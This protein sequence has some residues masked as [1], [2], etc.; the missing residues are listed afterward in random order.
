M[1]SK[2][3]TE[4]PFCVIITGDFN[5]RSAQWWENDMENNEGKFFEPLTS[6]LGLNQL[7]S[8]PTHLMGSSKS[9]IDLIF[10]DQP[11]LVIE[12]GVHPSLHEQCHHQIVHRKLS[13]SNIAVPPYTRRIWYYDKADFVNIMKS[14]E[15]FRWQE[16]IDKIACP[17]DQVKLLNEVLLNIYSNYIPNQVKT[18]RPRQAPWITQSVK[19]FLRKKIMHIRIS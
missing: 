19:K 4:R 8:E 1:V 10:T 14:I 17:K 5:C 2:M 18:I 15:M 13:V 7:I 11:N 12:T 9:C 3:N 16:H 6:D